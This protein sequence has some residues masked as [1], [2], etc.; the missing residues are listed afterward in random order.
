MCSVHLGDNSEGK[1]GDWMTGCQTLPSRPRGPATW[2]MA[3]SKPDIMIIL[4]SKLIEEGDGFYKVSSAHYPQGHKRESEGS[5]PALPVRS[6]EVPR[7]GFSEDLK[8]FRE[9]KV[10]LL[11]NLSRCRRKT[12][13]FGMAEEFATKALELKPNSYEAYYARARAKRSSRQFAEAL[14]DLNEA[15]KQCPNNR[16]IQRLLQRVEEECRQD[17]EPVQDLFEDEDYLEQELEAAS[18]GLPLES[19]PSPASLPIIQSPPPSPAH[20][21]S[22]YLSGLPLGQSFDFR[23]SPTSM[24]SPTRQGYQS[25]SPS[26]SPTHQNSHFRPS[27][28]QTSPAHQVSS[29]RFSPRPWA[30]EEGE[31]AEEEEEEEGGR[32]KTT[33]APR[34]RPCA[35]SPVQGQ[36]PVE[37]VC[38]YRS[39]SGSPVRYQQEQLPGRPKSP[40][41]KMSSQR[42]FQLSSQAS[43]SSQHHQQAGLR[44]QPAMAQIVRTNQPSSAVHSSAVLAGGAYGQM[45]HPISGRYQGGPPDVESRL[46]YQAS[47]DGRPMAQVQASLSAGRCASTAG[48]AGHPTRAWP[49]TSSRRGPPRRTGPAA[50]AAARGRALRADPADQPQP[51]GGLL[52]R[53]KHELDRAAAAGV[54]PQCQLGSP[55]IPHLQ[56]PVHGLRLQPGPRL[57]ALRLHPADGDPAA[58]LLRALLRRPLAHLALAGGRRPGGAVYQAEPARSRTTPFM[59]IIDKTART[60]QYLHQPSRPWAVSSLDTV[61]TSPTSPGNLAQQGGGGPSYSPPTSL[62]NIAYYNKTN[63]A[64]NGHLL[65][66]D[67]Y[68]Q[69]QPSSLG[70]LSNGSRGDILERVS[71]VP[72]YPDVKVARTLPV[73]QA[74]QD[75]MYRQLSRESRQGPT[76]PIKPKRPFVESN[77]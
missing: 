69:S 45:A 77:V 64:Q 7:E 17:M 1:A 12:N 47:L 37:S 2:A 49:R 38:L 67:Y 50:A 3:T 26:L 76:S 23:P 66:D 21:D 58:A 60:Q 72:T 19:R 68:S 13:D 25:T 70:K 10:S 29:Y 31:E 46:V 51:V 6:E 74:Y 42:S 16:E 43:Q 73:A 11:L 63:N 62:G 15:I 18:V 56:Q 20:R 44:L 55:E 65:E 36:P 48:G 33:R 8:T 14:E 71:Q 61:I 22:A 52:P 34:P 39:Q 27:P 32:G 53:L 57:P 4:L 59:G 24:S 35:G 40:L 54:L 41:S 5:S 30:A 28:P 75:N 9:L